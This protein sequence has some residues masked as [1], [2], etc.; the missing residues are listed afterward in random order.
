MLGF[1]RDKLSGWYIFVIKH[2]NRSSNPHIKNALKIHPGFRGEYSSL[3]YRSE[4]TISFQRVP[5]LARPIYREET[6]VNTTNL[7]C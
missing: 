7:I 5:V 6:S 4:V 3:I 1:E 2:L